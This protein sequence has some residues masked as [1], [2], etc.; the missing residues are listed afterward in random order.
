MAA[1]AAAAAEV[2]AELEAG[3]L[4]L[5]EEDYDLEENT[6]ESVEAL[7]NAPEEEE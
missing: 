1:L 2:E 4:R 6:P 3:S 7:G 5:E